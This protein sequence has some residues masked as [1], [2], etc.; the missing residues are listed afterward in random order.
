MTNKLKTL[1]AC[2]ALLSVASCSSAPANLGSDENVDVSKYKT[3]RWVS[4]ND[5]KVLRL[6]EPE[7]DFITGSSTVTSREDVVPRAR[8]VI[9]RALKDVGYQQVGDGTPDFF[10]TFYIKAKDQD[11]VS[12]W[13][14]ATDSINSTPLVIFPGYNRDMAYRSREDDFYVTFYDPKT[15]R[16]SWTGRVVTTSPMSNPGSPEAEHAASELFKELKKPA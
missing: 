16:P 14:G 6:E 10:V 15:L 7:V 2:S 3:Y 11:W 9:D 5:V 1:L 4:Q 13:Q 12:T 8:E